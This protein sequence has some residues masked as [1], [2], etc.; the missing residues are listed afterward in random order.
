MIFNEI[1]K[2]FKIIL[3]SELPLSKNLHKSKFCMTMNVQVNSN[4]YIY[5]YTNI[6]QSQTK[7]IQMLITYVQL[8][9][10]VFVY[11]KTLRPL[12]F[13]YFHQQLHHLPFYFATL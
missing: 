3:M 5:I 2:K 1:F 13:K 8:P 4:V 6:V 12:Y 7:N 10:Y 11:K 9:M